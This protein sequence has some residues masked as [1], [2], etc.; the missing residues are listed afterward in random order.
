MLMVASRGWYLPEK[1]I[2]V[3]GAPYGISGRVSLSL[4]A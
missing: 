4:A 1:R 2:L 3:D